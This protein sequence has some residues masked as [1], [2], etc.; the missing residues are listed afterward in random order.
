M[1]ATGAKGATGAMGATEATGVTEATVDLTTVHTASTAH[2][3]P[4]NPAL[5]N[6]KLQ[7]THRYSAPGNL[8]DYALLPWQVW[9]L[10]FVLGSTVLNSVPY[11]YGMRST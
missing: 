5:Q 9:I 1:A 4:R 8:D 7:L 3:L 2:L 11:P 10:S 6:T